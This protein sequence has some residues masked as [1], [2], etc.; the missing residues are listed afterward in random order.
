MLNAIIL[1][2]YL[3]TF[4][5]GMNTYGTYIYNSLPF[6]AVAGCPTVA[7]TIIAIP[8]ISPNPKIGNDTLICTNQG[9]QLNSNVNPPATYLWN[10]G[11]T[12]QSIFVSSVVGATVNYFVTVTNPQGCSGK[13]TIGVTFQVC[14]G[15]DEISNSNLFEIFTE[16]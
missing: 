15:I 8:S 5:P 4:T 2:G 6:G 9:L 7:D 3:G 10:T 16:I 13:D 11:S 14:N 1:I 12:L